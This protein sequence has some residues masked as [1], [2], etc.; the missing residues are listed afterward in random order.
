M[1]AACANGARRRISSTTGRKT[2]YSMALS[3]EGD[4]WKVA[5]SPP[6]SLAELQSR[7]VQSPAVTREGKWPLAALIAAVFATALLAACGSSDSDFE[8][9]PGNHQ[10]HDDNR[11][12]RAERRRL[13]E[14]HSQTARAR[15]G[16]QNQQEAEQRWWLWLARTSPRRSRSRAVA[17][18]QFRTKGG[19]NSIQEFGE[20]SDESE[21]QEAAETVHGFYVARAEERLGRAPA[22]TSRSRTSNS[23][24]SSPRSRP[25]SKATAAPDSQGLHPP[26][27]GRAYEREITTV[28]AGSLRHEGEQ[29]FL[30]YYGADTDRLRDAADRRRRQLEGRARSQATP[31]AEPQSRQ[32]TW[33]RSGPT[34]TRRIGTPTKSAM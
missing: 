14:R 11:H 26:A 12:H 23:S 17:P 21:L 1:P 30:I 34:P 13:P 32:T 18:A 7:P 33:S 10:R 24:N 16:S 6:N 3:R 8:L 2:V 15:T 31:S 25:S 22:P 20:E 29:G 27:A 19:D 9:Q 28:D 4:G 5:S